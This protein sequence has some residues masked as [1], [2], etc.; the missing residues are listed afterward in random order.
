[1]TKGGSSKIKIKVKTKDGEFDQIKDNSGNDA[2]PV[3][4]QEVDQIIQSP[5]GFKYVGTVL[6]AAYNPTCVCVRKANGQV[7]KVC[8]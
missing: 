8:R 4:Q 6:H 3:T 7:V 5:N 2:T 1:M